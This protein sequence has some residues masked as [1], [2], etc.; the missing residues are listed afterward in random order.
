MTQTDGPVGSALAGLA[1]WLAHA[2]GEGTP[3]VTAPPGGDTTRIC[4]WPLA[5]VPERSGTAPAPV[6]LRAR[7]A[8]V[9]D[10]PVE[11]A[12]S[13]VDRLL[14]A[15]ARPD[16]YQPVP[17]PVDPVLWQALGVAPRPALL[18]DIPLRL[19]RP[20][21]QPAPVARQ[22]RVEGGPLRRVHGRVVGPDGTGLPGVAVSAGDA[23]TRTDAHGDFV[24]STVSADTASVLHLTVHGR[25]LRVEVPAGS[26]DAVVVHCD[27]EE[28]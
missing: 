8:V 4:L 23:G 22:L 26:S 21:P 3:V 15:V 18:F 11:A 16:G 19:D 5:L 14:W 9:P 24:L 7:F 17:E 6:R 12:L 28:V 27:I 10:G 13:I 20:A 25:H 2:A 1:G